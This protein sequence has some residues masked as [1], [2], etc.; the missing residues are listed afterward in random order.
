MT[1]PYSPTTHAALSPVCVSCRSGGFLSSNAARP[2]EERAVT[3]A[4]AADLG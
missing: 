1:Q 4:C 3:T 2:R